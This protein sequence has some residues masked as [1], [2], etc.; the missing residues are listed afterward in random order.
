MI[1]MDKGIANP[2]KKLQDI[3][4]KTNKEF[5]QYVIERVKIVYIISKSILNEF[6]NNGVERT[7]QTAPFNTM[8]PRLKKD[9]SSFKHE[10]EY[11]FYLIT[12]VHRLHIELYSI[13]LDQIVNKN[14]S[15]E[16]TDEFYEIVESMGLDELTT[17]EINYLIN[18][19]EF[20]IESAMGEIIDDYY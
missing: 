3:F 2:K 7:S 16:L 15:D 5:E 19:S 18:V 17:V 13:T 12:E 10:Q 6:K 4:L 1:L 20:I 9:R 8:I 11:I 14:R